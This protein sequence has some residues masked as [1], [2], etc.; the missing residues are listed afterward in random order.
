MGRPGERKARRKSKL[1][2]RRQGD[3]RADEPRDLRHSPG[4]SAAGLQ[5]SP[6]KALPPFASS[7]DPIELSRLI[8]EQRVGVDEVVGW[9]RY[10]A[11]ADVSERVKRKWFSWRRTGSLPDL[12]RRGLAESTELVGPRGYAVVQTTL[13]ALDDEFYRLLHNQPA[14]ELWT[15][16]RHVSPGY[17]AVSGWDTHQGVR[18]IAELA[19]E[20]FG[21]W[22]GFTT[23]PYSWSDSHVRVAGRCLALAEAYYNLLSA[24]RRI[25]KGQTA[26][27]AEWGPLWIDFTDDSDLDRLIDVRDRRSGAD[28]NPFARLGSVAPPVRHPR[29]TRRP[30]RVTAW[31]ADPNAP[32]DIE[33]VAAGARVVRTSY[34]IPMWKDDVVTDW[35][36]TPN[37]RDLEDW[38]R[39]YDEA[40]TLDLGY[41][42]RDL[43][44][45]HALLTEALFPGFDPGTLIPSQLEFCG[46]GMLPRSAFDA[47][48]AGQAAQRIGLVD[49][50]KVTPASATAAFDGLCKSPESAELRRLGRRPVWC[51]GGAMLIDFVSFDL[52]YH[53]VN[54]L[55]SKGYFKDTNPFDFER[56]VHAAL[57]AFGR[58]PVAQGRKV[59][60]LDGTEITDIDASVVI[61][62]TLV[63]VDCFSS[64]WRDDLDEGTH[65]A[66]RNRLTEVKKKL[67]DWDRKMGELCDLAPAWLSE[68]GVAEVFPVVVTATPEWIDE[69]DDYWWLSPEIPRA[70]TPEEL[71]GVVLLDR[72]LWRPRLPLAN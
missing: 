36:D 19:V 29:T 8:S 10:L 23:L 5:Q 32:L 51:Q 1:A 72:K 65:G 6:A 28:R 53:L 69:S 62:T 14:V 49:W 44:A 71:T 42:M 57:A 52:E 63:A 20:K 33:A 4:G 45:V 43:L 38:C 16:L 58:Q 46:Y 35:A 40:L 9:P 31:F 30:A 17:W 55:A 41:T 68:A 3:R 50:A 25:A 48:G 56:R 61:G 13:D 67:R 27:V 12:L 15:C 7:W 47:S 59:T 2:R 37:A 26:V 64:P 18:R 70:C 21:R 39:P 60:R 24:R 54:H 11:A 22:D 66:T 34:G